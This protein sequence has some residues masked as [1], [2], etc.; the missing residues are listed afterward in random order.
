MDEPSSALDMESEAKLIRTLLAR[1]E[2]G[3][4][5]IVASHRSA[6]MDAAN[7]VVRLDKSPRL[8]GK[9]LGP[10]PT[11]APTARPQVRGFGIE[12]FL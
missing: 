5:I 2:A 7:Q 9:E 11:Q 8:S 4:M 6:F 1:R 12:W 10:R 3:A